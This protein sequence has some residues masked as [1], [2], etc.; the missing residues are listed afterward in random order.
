MTAIATKAKPKSI[1]KTRLT[2]EELAAA[3]LERHTLATSYIKRLRN[4]Y[5]SL[6]DEKSTIEKKQE[7]IKER[8][9]ATLR[10]LDAKDFIDVDGTPIIGYIATTKVELDK[11]KLAAKFGIDAL[12]DC[13]TT[14]K[15]TRFFSKK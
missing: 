12:K 5:N 11:E 2:E 1:A 13:F 10:E 14:K 9:A 3:R 8:I 15:G 6:S 4:Q 7:I